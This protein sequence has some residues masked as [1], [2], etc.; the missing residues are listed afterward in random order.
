MQ[1]N[2][3]IEIINK[4]TLEA[5][6]L[7]NEINDLKRMLNNY[8][9]QSTANFTNEEKVNIFMDYFKGRDSI[10]PYLSIDK[11]DPSK[12]IIYLNVRMNGIK[13]SVIKQWVKNVRIANIGLINR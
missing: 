3:I 13:M 2:E 10:Y 7:I 5:K 4:K 11:K 12:N 9:N 1:R 6:K 8:D